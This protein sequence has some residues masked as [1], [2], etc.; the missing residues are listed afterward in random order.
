MAFGSEF[1]AADGETPTSVE[2]VCRSAKLVLIEKRQRRELCFLT[3]FDSDRPGPVFPYSIHNIA[4]VGTLFK[5][6]RCSVGVFVCLFVLYCAGLYYFVC[7]FV[8]QAI[9]PSLFNDCIYVK[10]FYNHLFLAL[11][12]DCRLL[13]SG[14]VRVLLPTCSSCL[15]A[16]TLTVASHFICAENASSTEKTSSCSPDPRPGTKVTV[17]C[18]IDCVL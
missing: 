7:L 5:K 17:L 10:S 16:S 14:L 4:H 15:F 1:G 8:F 12:V 13:A 9:L 3:F 11:F 18:V 6:V 2:I